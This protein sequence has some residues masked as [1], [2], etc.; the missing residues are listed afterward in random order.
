MPNRAPKVCAQP[1]CPELTLSGRCEKHQQERVRRYDKARGTAAERGYDE[2]WR[3]ARVDY[4]RRNSLC[5]ICKM[6]RRM[7]PATVV[8]HIKPH[9]GDMKLFWN[10]DNWQSLCTFHHNAKT[11]RGG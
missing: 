10:V 6:N 5:V 4:L 7:T 2:R 11:A 1:G 8:D 9:R 3:S